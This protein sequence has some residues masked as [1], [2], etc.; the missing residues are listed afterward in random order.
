MK[1]LIRVKIIKLIDPTERIEGLQ[2]EAP[3]PGSPIDMNGMNI[4]QTVKTQA[5]I[6][7]T[8]PPG[9]IKNAFS[10]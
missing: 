8:G 2:V 3:D 1:I 5:P 9:S 10:V 6:Y 7:R 4:G